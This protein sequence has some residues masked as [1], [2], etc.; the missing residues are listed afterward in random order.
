MKERAKEYLKTA[1]RDRNAEFRV[2]QWE[3]IEKIVSGKRRLLLVQ[4]TGWGKSIVYFIATR[5]LRDDGA[6]PTLLISPLLALMRNQIEAAE[7]I[8]IRAAT[9]NSDNQ[10][11]WERV[12]DALG[13][14]EVDI[15]LVSPE[16]LAN[17]DF[18]EKFLLP[19]AP[20]IG[21]FVVD[22]AHC[23]SDWGHDFRP[24]YRRIVRILNVLPGNVPVLTTT[25]TA[26]DRVINDVVDQLG[27]GL[28][29]SRG[30]LA[31]ESLRLQNIEL[32]N[33]AARMAWLAEQLPKLPGSGI[34]YALTVRDCE[35]LAEWLR[36]RRID[37]RAYHGRL[38]EGRVALEQA[39]LANEVKVL[40]ATTALGM[41]FDKPDL[42]FVIHFQRPGS[43]V[44]YYQQVGRAGRQLD[45]AYGVLL[46]GEEDD[47]IIEYFIRTAFPP[48]E[49]VYKVLAALERAENGL[50]IRQLEPNV[51]LPYRQLEKVLK[52]LSVEVPSPIIKIKS[53]WYRGP[54]QYEI[55]SQ[56]VQRLRDIRHHEQRRMQ[57]YV[58]HKG[59]LMK[60]LAEELNDPDADECGKCAGC[61]K[62]P[63]LPET[64]SREMLDA[65]LK[66][67]ERSELPIKPRK[68]WPPG[69]LTAYNFSGRIK[70]ELLAKEG[71]A[72]CVWGDPGWGDMVRH[73]KLDAGRFDDQLVG[74]SSEM[75]LERWQPEPFPTWVT[76][77][78]S[79]NRPELV[80][81]FARRL[82]DV[83]GLPFKP[84]MKKVRETKLQKEMENSFH[85]ARNL[86]GAFDII[87]C[88]GF[89]RPVLLVDDM[90]DSGWT[91]T[92]AAALLRQYGSGPVFPFALAVTTK[93][94]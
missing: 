20:K 28:I 55:D 76:C 41:G 52:I 62:G 8:D 14:D 38:Y 60:F 66:F 26:N 42:G 19:V 59:C 50:S 35:R 45:N 68:L 65:A 79:S 57:E 30:R 12:R 73:G 80:P 90:V 72:L 23:I 83:L 36:S 81:D 70:P 47:E 92:V 24:D 31:R 51:N 27:T 89:E 53:K 87:P 75:I 5:L 43:V 48:E 58:Q 37:A 10:D 64:Y 86:D 1:L 18:L 49:Q 7:R 69:A 15:L 2:G 32:P 46:C 85:Q 4:R 16:R 13:K 61:T 93:G 74:A 34:I 63:I 71:R 77:M 25:A 54:E 88:D 6:G 82:A 94:N 11:E 67:L 56:R 39:L 33:K 9:V 44:H 29:V 3:S 84:C 91:L 40:V 22:E 17:S 21:L 78:L